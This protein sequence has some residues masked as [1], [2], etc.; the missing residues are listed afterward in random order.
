MQQLKIEPLWEYVSPT[1]IIGLFRMKLHVSFTDEQPIVV[2]N[3]SVIAID[4]ID[5]KGNSG[6]FEYA[7]PFEWHFEGEIQSLQ[8]NVLEPVMQ[9]KDAGTCVITWQATASIEDL[10]EESAKIE[11]PVIALEEPLL[12]VTQPMQ[13]E[14][15]VEIEQVIL[16]E[17]KVEV[18]QSIHEEPLAE[19]ARPIQE[20]SRVEVA[21]SI[22]E[23]PKVEVAQPV[24]IEQKIEVVK[25]PIKEKP[26]VK[27]VLPGTGELPLKVTQSFPANSQLEVSQPPKKEVVRKK[28]SNVFLNDLVEQY[29]IWRSNDLHPK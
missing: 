27:V 2:S 24:Q 23:E 18:V 7:L 25:P 5:V 14:P 13:E 6:Y 12:E 3:P 28:E 26:Q 8:V 19:V 15:L 29:S 21:Q 20:E 10:F 17:P 16:E 9:V 22:Q 1:H 4:Q 11:E